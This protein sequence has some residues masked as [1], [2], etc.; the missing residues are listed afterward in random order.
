MSDT[1]QNLP[2]S[3]VERVTTLEFKLSSVTKELESIKASHAK[4]KKETKMMR[5]VTEVF[6][7]IPGGARGFLFFVIGVIFISSITAEILLRTT[8][9]HLTIRRH[10]IEVLTYKKS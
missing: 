10:L 1:H 5:E 4:H 3:F 7:W 6:S 2:D 9:I 8:N